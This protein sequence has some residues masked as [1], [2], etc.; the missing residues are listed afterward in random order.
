MVIVGWII[1]VIQ[2]IA[3]GISIAF[4]FLE[5][6]GTKRLQYFFSKY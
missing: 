2:I 6:K 1:F 5:D 3:E 4:S